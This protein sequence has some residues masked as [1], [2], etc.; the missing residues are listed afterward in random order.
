MRPRRTTV[1]ALLGWYLIRRTIS[2]WLFVVLVLVIDAIVFCL[3]PWPLGVTVLAW[4]ILISLLEARKQKQQW[5]D[6]A[7]SSRD[8]PA[9]REPH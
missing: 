7:T 2:V 4:L 6:E 1:L 5:H 8:Y 9:Q 3:F